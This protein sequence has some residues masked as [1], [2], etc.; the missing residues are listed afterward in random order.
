LLASASNRLLCCGLLGAEGGSAKRLRREKAP[1]VMAEASGRRGGG[2]C[3]N[4]VRALVSTK[5]RGDGERFLLRMR[6]TGKEKCWANH[7]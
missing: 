2:G 7:E 1:Q 4:W 3:R 6:A 5:S